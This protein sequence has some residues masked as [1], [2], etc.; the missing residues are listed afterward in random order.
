MLLPKELPGYC[1]KIMQYRKSSDNSL[2]R[3]TQRS[4]VDI[5]IP[6]V[7][8]RRI[9]YFITFLFNTPH[10][11]YY[12]VFAI[13]Y[14]FR[15]I[16]VLKYILTLSYPAA[17]ILKNIQAW[18]AVSL[19]EI[20][21]DADVLPL[22]RIYIKPYCCLYPVKNSIQAVIFSKKIQ[23]SSKGPVKLEFDTIRKSQLIA[24]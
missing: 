4:V 6:G 7:K 14:S 17:D 10:W 19:D 13:K 3:Y 24:N 11:L 18:R 2:R 23:P 20:G 1:H 16:N 15:V 12:T 22:S 21:E 9:I 5:G 8:Q